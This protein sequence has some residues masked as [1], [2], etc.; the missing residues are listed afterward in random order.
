[1]LDVTKLLGK[2]RLFQ[3]Q[4]PRISEVAQWV[5][6][7]HS[8]LSLLKDFLDLGQ[9]LADNSARWSLKGRSLGCGQDCLGCMSL[10]VTR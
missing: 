2:G 1:M 3:P 9:G 8:L 7:G 6:Q 10:L 5:V 4:L